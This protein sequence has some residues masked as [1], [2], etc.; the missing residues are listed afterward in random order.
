MLPIP[1]QSATILAP[2]LSSAGQWLSAKSFSVLARIDE[3]NGRRALAK[4]AWHSHTLTVRTVAGYGGK[5]GERYEVFAPSLPPEL[6]AKWLAARAAQPMPEAPSVTLT[7]PAITHDPTASKRAARA[8]WILGII[9][10]IIGLKRHTPERSAAIAEALSR[11]YTDPEGKSVRISQTRLYDWLKR[12]DDTHVEGLKPRQRNDIGKRRVLVTRE[13]DKAAPLD[14]E[15]K[16]AIAEALADYV[17]SLWAS[18]AAGWAVIQEFSSLKLEELSRT[19]GWDAPAMTLKPACR[20]SRPFI[21]RYRKSGLLAVSDKDAKRFFDEHIPRIRRNRADL[22]PMDVV[23]GDVHPV[24]IAIRRVDGSIAYPRAICWHD[25]ATNRLFVCL[26]LLE[27]GEGVKQMHVASAFASMCAAWGLPRTL[28]LDNGSEYSWHEMMAAFSEISRLTQSLQTQF[29]VGELPAN[30]Q[31]RELVDTQRQIVRAQPYNAPAKPI[32]GLFSVIEGTVLSMMPGWTGG[33]RMRAKTA[34]VGRTPEPYPGTW[35]QFHADFETAL[36]FYHQRPQHGTMGGKSPAEVYEGF[37]DAGWTRTHVEERVL[38]LSFAEEDTRKVNGGYISWDGTDYY[39]DVLLRYTGQTLTV[40]VCRHDPRHAYVFDSN[41]SL[42]CAAAVAPV[43]GFMDPAGAQE[44]A[45]RKKV[46]MRYIAELRE[47]VCRLDLVAEM[48][49]VVKAKG[50]MAQAA[51]GAT[52]TMSEAALQMMKEVTA[53]EDAALIA[54]HATTETGEAGL[55]RLS[56]WSSPDERD[57]YLEG[58]TFADEETT[59]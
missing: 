22:L 40:R 1:P 54:A 57:P 30:G 20:L 11:E 24:D 50:P 12:Y 38:L 10:P 16:Q 51:I 43:F 52:V 45:R 56:Q 19:A 49:K 32:E 48:A 34:N 26:V 15:A 41:R 58:V 23:V 42:L 9:R 28:Y 47:N 2:T 36:A 59:S 3:R 29:A 37:I 4:G 31:W 44:Q 18:G 46:L 55:R 6:Y 21:E 35:E 53:K 7:I 14:E 8:L 39:D 33:D 27:K 13:W 17:R 25:V 5:S